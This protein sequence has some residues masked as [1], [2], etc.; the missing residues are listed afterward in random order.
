[1]DDL[2]GSRMANTRTLAAQVLFE[3]DALTSEMTG[4]GMNFAATPTKDPNIEDVLISASVNGM[5]EDDL[6]T[7]AV[8]VTWIGIHN[9][10][11]NADRLLRAVHSQPSTRVRA[12][13]AAIGHWLGKDRRLAR[14]TMVYQGPRL[15]LLP[16]GTDFQIR[17]RGEDPRFA[18]SPLRVP[19]GVVRDRPA[20]VL[21]PRE[22]T[23]RHRTYRQRVLMGPSYRADMWAA[24]ESQPP[25]SG[26][27][28]ARHTYG[29]FATAWQVKHDW[30]LLKAG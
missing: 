11:I 26:A 1:M 4:I 20:D 15:D 21:S 16:T 10:W 25:L 8:L 30:E 19:G 23:K 22:L 28:L 12:F 2:G 13:W 9:S 17:R 6:R 27:A 5:E 18:D 3:G 7:L 14:L 29:S 24:L